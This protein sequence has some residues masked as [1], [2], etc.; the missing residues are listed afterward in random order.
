MQQLCVAHNVTFLPCRVGAPGANIGEKAQAVLVDAMVAELL[1]L[2]PKAWQYQMQ[3]AQ[4]SVTQLS[5]HIA[6]LH[7]H[8]SLLEIPVSHSLLQADARLETQCLLTESLEVP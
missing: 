4:Q 7:A 6:A 1:A 2:D 3:H 5:Q 8:I